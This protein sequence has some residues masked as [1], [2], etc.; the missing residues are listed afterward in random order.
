MLQERITTVITAVVA[1]TNLTM[2][3]ITPRQK[4][5]ITMDKNS[6]IPSKEEIL[7]RLRGDLAASPI[8]T[9]SDGQLKQVEAEDILD[10]KDNE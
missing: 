5:V 4:E 9:M 8:F 2:A 10:H 6:S 7:K 3:T 1:V